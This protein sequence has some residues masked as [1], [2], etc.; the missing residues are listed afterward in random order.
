[1]T[2]R[3]TSRFRTAFRRLPPEI[4]R[5]AHRTFQAWKHQP[6]R[7]SLQFKQV[8]PTLAVYSVRVGAHWRAVGVKRQDGMVWFWI[9]SH[10]D[11]DKLLSQL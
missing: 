6:D 4:R 11:Y 10:S 9:G 1:M 3:T 7:P 8:H 5:L 2:S